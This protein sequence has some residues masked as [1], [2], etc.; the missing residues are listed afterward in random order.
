M[1]GADIATTVLLAIVVLSAAISAIGVLLA[2][3]F[4]ERLHYLSI[5]A[6]VGVW[7]LAAAVL[8]KESID[9]AGIKAVLIAAVV[10]L[11]N[12]VLTHATARAG[13]TRQYGSLDIRPEEKANRPSEG[14][15]RRRD[16]A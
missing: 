4:Y 6:T 7:S 5:V 14:A 11:M 1:R 16:A 8:V 13:R 2:K 10:F 12:S 3:D 9:Q 15:G